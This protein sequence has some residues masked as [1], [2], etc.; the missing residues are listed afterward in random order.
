LAAASTQTLLDRVAAQLE[1]MSGVADGGAKRAFL[2]TRLAAELRTRGEA[3]LI[4]LLERAER[5]DSSADMSLRNMLTVNYSCFWREPEHWPILAEHLRLRF[6]ARAPVRMWSA[7][8]A[9]GEEAWTMALVAAEVA[10]ELAQLAP[11]WTILGSDIDTVSL[12]AA[13]AGR[14]A[15]EDLGSLPDRLRE[16]LI[17]AGRP[18]APRREVPAALR[19][20]VEY[21]YLDLARA[22]W[23]PPQEAPFDAIFLSNV[24]IYFERATQER[25]LKNVAGCLRPDGIV[26]TSRVEGNLGLATR[27]L[28]AA[29]NCTYIT[30]R[31]AR[32]V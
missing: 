15:N 22:D 17:L 32:R 10:T 23:Q 25:I 8:C 5:G 20:H 16:Q 26:F 30:A 11:G 2:A 3:A 28:K 18:N 6:E 27:Q 29:G 13:R 31:T 21:K 12:D 4:A 14:Y 7:A 9:R 24:L 1:R 19:Q